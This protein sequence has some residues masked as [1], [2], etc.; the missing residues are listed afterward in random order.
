[1]ARILDG[2]KN[3]GKFE[4]ERK[5][6]LRI[7]RIVYKFSTGRNLLEAIRAL[8]DVMTTDGAGELKFLI[9]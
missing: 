2:K 9:F 6:M 1:V 8:L 7:I 3:L 4:G 5:S